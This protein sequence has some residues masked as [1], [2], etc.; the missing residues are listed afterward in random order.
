[1]RSVHISYAE[2]IA[3]YTGVNLTPVADSLL[4]KAVGSITPIVN[5]DTT[6]EELTV[7]IEN[8]AS[9]ADQS[10]GSFSESTD[11]LVENLIEELKPRLTFIQSVVAPMSA[12]YANR[13]QL[14]IRDLPTTSTLGYNVI[15]KC[16]PDLYGY[17]DFLS[18]C[19]SYSDKHGNSPTCEE[20]F[21]IFVLPESEEEIIQSLQSGF[22]IYDEMISR[23]IENENPEFLGAAWEKVID[24]RAFN[25]SDGRRTFATRIGNS[26]SE[27]AAV[28]VMLDAAIKGKLSVGVR[29]NLDIDAAKVFMYRIAGALS[30]VILKEIDEY[31]NKLSNGDLLI[32]ISHDDE[33][34]LVRDEVYR[35]FIARKGT[36]ELISALAYLKVGNN[37]NQVEFTIDSILSNSDRISEAFRQ[38][39]AKIAEEMRVKT[40]LSIR[41]IMEHTFSEMLREVNYAELGYDEMSEDVVNANFV[42]KIKLV[43]DYDLEERLTDACI[44]LFIV[45]VWPKG[46]F[47]RF[48]EEMNEFMARYPEENPRKAAYR[49]FELEIARTLLSKVAL[50][51]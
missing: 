8:A 41:R 20:T 28:L 30:T 24:T 33:T 44:K 5:E 2:T 51:D 38:E 32:E 45:V 1:M 35:Q 31:E 10:L 21:N 4:F 14:A 47:Y 18:L 17:K 48:I 29:N 22:K 25:L 43:T 19:N 16:V 3:N 15:P 27:N 34:I 26:V 50:A 37:L 7:A 13:V 11:A 23:L 12:K 6:S 39:G 49:A 46:D 40:N 9:P 36:P 42:E